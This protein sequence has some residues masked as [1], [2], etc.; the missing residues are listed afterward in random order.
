MVGGHRGVRRG[1]NTR[2]LAA[3]L[4][5]AHDLAQPIECEQRRWVAWR[6][7]CRHARIVG[8]T[9]GERRVSPIR[10]LDDQ[11]WI[12]TLSDPDQLDLLTAQRV[13]GMGDRDRFRRRLGQWGS[14]L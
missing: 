2:P 5:E 6:R 13:I 8:G 1:G 11:V 14:V 7:L 10:E 4:H 9:H 12:N 3:A